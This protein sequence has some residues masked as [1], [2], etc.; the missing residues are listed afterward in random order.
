MALDVEILERSFKSLAPRGEA[1]VAAFYERLFAAAPEVK[2]LFASTDMGTQQ[3]KLLAALALTVDNLRRPEIL[4]PVLRDLG[5]KHTGYGV[6]PDAAGEAGVGRCLR[7]DHRADARRGER[8]LRWERTRRRAAPPRLAGG[9][10]SRRRRPGDHSRRPLRFG[11]AHG[12]PAGH[13]VERSPPRG[14]RL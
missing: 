12:V 10:P 2:P 14:G 4:G 9:R 6:K 11:A 8:E 13:D 5:K 7:R 1:F 3:K